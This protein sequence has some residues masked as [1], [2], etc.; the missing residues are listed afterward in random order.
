[1]QWD[2]SKHF[3]EHIQSDRRTGSLNAQRWRQRIHTKHKMTRKDHEV[4]R[5]MQSMRYQEKLIQRSIL[6]L[7]LCKERTSEKNWPGLRYCLCHWD[8]NWQWNIRFPEFNCKTDK[9]HGNCFDSVDYHCST[10]H[11]GCIL[12]V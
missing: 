6:Q 5:Q 7:R 4:P 11:L 1:M 8:I 10:L 2:G 3:K 12:S 9:Q